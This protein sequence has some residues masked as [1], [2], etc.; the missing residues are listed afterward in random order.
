M[1]KLMWVEDNCVDK[2]KAL[3]PDAVTVEQVGITENTVLVTYLGRGLTPDMFQ[4]VSRKYK[5]M[6]EDSIASLEQIT[7][8]KFELIF[9]QDENH[10]KKL[11]VGYMARLGWFRGTK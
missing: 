2:V 10:M 6:L 4:K 9:A 3:D 11:D 8:K 5:L 7:K 1:K